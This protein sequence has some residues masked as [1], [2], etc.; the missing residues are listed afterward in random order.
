M[1][2]NAKTDGNVS[3][4]KI[5][6]WYVVSNF[7]T[8]AIGNLTTPIFARMMSTSDYGKFSN[9]LTWQN[10]I[11]II[12]SLS[13]V[14]TI[15]KAKYDYAENIEEYLSTMILFGNI[16]GIV[17]WVVIELNSE[18]VI[19]IFNMDMKYIRIML[20]DLLFLPAF[21][22][23]QAFFRIYNKYK[24]FVFFSLSSAIIRTTVSIILIM[25]M[26]DKFVARIIGYVT[27]NIIMNFALWCYIIYKGRKFK[28]KYCTYA[29]P[30]A[31]PMVINSIAGNILVSSDRIMITEYCG[32]TD[33]AMYTMAYSCST[34]ASVLWTALNQA[35]TP[36]LFD[37]LYYNER[38]IVHKRTKI[39]VSLY[40]ALILGFM[41]ILPEILW[42]FGGDKY[43]VVQN[44]VPIIFSS[45]YCQFVYSL[46]V[47]V[48]TYMK[49]T[50]YSMIGTIMAAGINVIL[51]FIVI[52][53]WG[54]K[55]AAY[56]TFIAYLLLA[57]FHAIIIQLTKEYKNLYDD[58]FNFGL[59]IIL[60]FYM[61]VCH[62]LYNLVI[63]R[64]IFIMIY[65]IIMLVALFMFQRQK[66]IYKKGK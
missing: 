15:G 41:L 56:T 10:L 28:W 38:S 18:W 29:L 24:F 45:V 14:T 63:V 4:T 59:I 31:L 36:W 8:V 53:V 39:F 44:I 52:P 34:I 25:V 26:E 62:V 12:F 3:T 48:E 23:L 61:G 37:R 16:V 40:F 54:Y 51:N 46:Y 1:K 21:S 35:W 27:P 50:H 7:L 9:F 32:A 22:L 30:F 47:N 58:K 19:E 6:F 5:A 42:F 11:L 33:T 17:L 66:N 13:L 55:A 20:L 65:F 60:I 64:S 49:K 43:M 57:V 2:K